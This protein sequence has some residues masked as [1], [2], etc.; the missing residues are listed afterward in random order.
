[1]RR[2]VTA[3]MFIAAV[4][5]I[6]A[7]EL[8]MLASGAVERALETLE[9]DYRQQGVAIRL[10]FDTTP[11]I[12]KRLAS[13]ETPDVLIAAAATVDQLI[14]KGRAI[15]DSRAAIGR[16]GIGVAVGPG[17]RHPDIST[18]DALK[19][20]LRQADSVLLT[21]GAAGTYLETA[22]RDIGVMD[23]ISGKVT[24]MPTG[25]ALTQ[26]LGSG[27]GSQIGFTMISEL[28]LGAQYGAAYVG[29]LPAGLQRPSA[30]DA[31]VM[32]GSRAPDA[33]RAF[34]RYITT[35]AARKLFA[36]DGWEF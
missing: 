30:Y 9:R 28:K 32:S 5:P 20:A 15:A 8:S 12:T 34:V 22:L 21:Q 36:A 33:A 24:R 6:A 19:N 25:V 27:K 4:G 11:N 2:A 13:G 3:L 14:K 23:Q 26:R 7:A 18:V 17:S 1:M 16:I 31:V 29:P 10:Q 35:P